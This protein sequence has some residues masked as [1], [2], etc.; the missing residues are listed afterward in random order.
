MRKGW[1]TTPTGCHGWIAYY[2]KTLGNQEFMASVGVQLD[3]VYKLY[4]KQ[5][6]YHEGRICLLYPPN[7]LI[8]A[9]WAWLG[10]VPNE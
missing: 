4:G 9:W 1:R 6:I 5:S 7:M 3:Q 8:I 2:D 10:G